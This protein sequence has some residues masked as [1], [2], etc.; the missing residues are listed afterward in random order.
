MTQSPVLF[1]IF[2]RIETTRKVFERIREA[3]PQNLYIAADGPRE[4]M[5]EKNICESVRN[6]VINSVDWQCNV[7]TLFRDKNLGCG[8]A[9]SSSISWFFKNVE[10]GIILEDDC[11][12]DITFFKF[13]DELLDRYKNTPEVCSISGTN[14][15]GSADRLEQSYFFSAYGGIWGWATWRRVW[16]G[17]DYNALIWSD[18]KFQL[19][20]R[21]RFTRKQYKYIKLMLGRFSNIDTWD[22]QW[23]I[24][25]LSLNAFDIIPKN[26]LVKNLGFNSNSTHTKAIDPK[27]KNINLGVANFPLIHP[28]DISHDIYHDKIISDNFYSMPTVRGRKRWITRVVLR[29]LRKQKKR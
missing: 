26:N 13:C 27:M 10:Y 17:Y 23:W 5:N 12:P 16:E 8:R 19:S 11:F 14:L 15:L 20:L 1:L 3:E 21:K 18:K 28:K 6:W 24:R 9:V 29:F 4:S 25:K 7:F 2:N 22:F